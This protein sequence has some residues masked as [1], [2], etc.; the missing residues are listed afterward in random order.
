MR[1]CPFVVGF[2]FAVAAFCGIRLRIILA[3][4]PIHACASGHYAMWS[5][6]FFQLVSG[7]VCRPVGAALYGLPFW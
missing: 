5:V 3:V 1:D 7:F 6:P 2:A 4:A